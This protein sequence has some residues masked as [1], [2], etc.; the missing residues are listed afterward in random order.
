MPGDERLEKGD[1]CFGHVRGYP[2]WPARVTEKEMKGKKKFQVTF[3]GTNETARLSSQDLKPVS[4]E[5]IRKFVT[6]SAFKRKH[7]KQGFEE[8]KA[9]TNQV[10]RD[11]SNISLENKRSSYCSGPI[12]LQKSFPRDRSK[13]LSSLS[14]ALEE[15]DVD[16]NNAAGI[17]IIVKIEADE[18]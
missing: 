6:S 18:I 7:F 8:M 14:A 17:E 13:F 11:V 5:N 4:E 12:V 1:N 9:C 3:Y 10:L 2:W 16:N 15:I